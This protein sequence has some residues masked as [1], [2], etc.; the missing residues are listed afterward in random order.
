MEPCAGMAYKGSWGNAFSVNL[1]GAA[2]FPAS[3][4]VRM[5]GI[6]IAENPR[7]LQ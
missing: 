6:L 1:P 7:L 4:S 3:G 2:I 5:A